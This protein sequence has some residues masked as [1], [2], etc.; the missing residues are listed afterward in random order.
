MK[1][2]ASRMLVLA[3][4]PW[5][6]GTLHA[7]EADV[8][9]LLAA[10]LA[11]SGRAEVFVEL[12]SGAELAAA[13][14]IGDRG[15]RRQYVYD[16]LTAHAAASQ[17]ELKAFLDRR[18]IGYESFWIDNSVYL[19]AAD[20]ALV[21]E[22]A[23]RADVVRLRA[24]RHL[25]L[26]GAPAPGATAPAAV[27]PNIL[28]I[29]ADDVWAQGYTGQGIV[30]AS[31]DTGVRYTHEALRGQYRGNNGDGSYSHDY[32]W[33]DPRH[34]LAEPADNNG[35]G[36]HL[37]GI[38]VGGDG[39]GPLANDI[40][41]APGARWI[42]AK[43]CESASC[44]QFSLL[45][46]AQWVACPTR[47]DGSDPDCAQAPDVVD[48]GWGGAGGDPWYQAAVHAWR[49]AGIVPVFSAGASGPGCRT[50]GSPADYANV[51]GVG[52]S[53]ANDVLM[54]FSG[55]GPGTFRP[56]KPDFVAPGENIRSA[57]S[58]SDSAYV[59]YSGT[60]MATSH[61]TGTVALVL[62]VRPDPGYAAILR[63]LA[64]GAERALGAPPS[65][66]SCA[67]RSYDEYPNFIYGWGRI[68]AAGAVAAILR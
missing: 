66:T 26:G 15:A 44:S 56:L 20:A 29:H 6:A 54:S 27:E 10:Q 46:A 38:G 17:R 36:T 52:A 51:I 49:A 65:P 63:A 47:V 61:V 68:D 33:W 53:D 25:P 60:S 62:S 34:G 48:N 21:R 30:V 42:A 31:I 22:L 11:H 9:A 58:A 8:D 67:G 1:T 23:A 43:G 37:L 7:A 4:A 32:H 45:S 64:L 13:A 24:E 39:F 18:A 55:R 12:G 40:G 14:A 59:I 57:S 35:H 50:V 5:L 41:V 16:T 3:G 19:R 28:R 2:T